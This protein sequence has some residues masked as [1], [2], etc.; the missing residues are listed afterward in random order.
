MKRGLRIQVQL[1]KR[2]LLTRSHNPVC[3][4]DPH[5]YTIVALWEVESRPKPKENGA[6]RELDPRRGA[7]SSNTRPLEH[8]FAIL[9]PL[10]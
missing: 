5:R 9:L 7:K 10:P 2:T 1:G 4:L 8:R 6:V 3:L